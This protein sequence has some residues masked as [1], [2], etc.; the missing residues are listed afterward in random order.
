[1][2]QLILLYADSP[3]QKVRGHDR[4]IEKVPHAK[5]IRL[6]MPEKSRIWKSPQNLPEGMGRYG[7]NSLRSSMC[8]AE[9]TMELLAAGAAGGATVAMAAIV[10]RGKV[11][12]RII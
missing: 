3:C 2:C 7:S 11:D 8:T 12:S 1:M 5:I 9:G 6:S 4:D 10:A